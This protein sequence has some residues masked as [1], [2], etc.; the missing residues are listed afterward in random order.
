MKEPSQGDAAAGDVELRT[1]D[2]LAALKPGPRGRID[3]FGQTGVTVQGIRHT[4]MGKSAAMVALAAIEGSPSC[5]SVAGMLWPES[6]ES[7]AR[8][9]LRTLRH[10]LT[11]QLGVELLGSGENLSISSQAATVG[12]LDADQLVTEL[13][14]GGASRCMLLAD[15]GLLELEQFQEWLATARQRINRQQL[16][17]LDTALGAAMDSGQSARAIGFARACVM[18]EPLSERWHRQLMHTHTAC[19]DR[20]A[21]LAAYEACK[22]TLLDNLGATPDDRTRS[23]HLRI[24]RSQHRDHPTGEVAPAPAPVDSAA[25]IERDAQ[26]ER[27][28][29]A[30]SRGLSMVLH[31]EAGVG[32]T[33]LR[34]HFSQGKPVLAVKLRAGAGQ[35]PFSAL[36]Q[37]LLAAQQTHMLVLERI[38]R[39]ELSRVAPQAFPDDQPSAATI[40]MARLRE[41]VVHWSEMLRAKGVT[42]LCIDDLH[43]A[44]TRSQSAFAA[45]IEP[46]PDPSRALPVL[47]SYRSG[48]IAGDL[49]E[50]IGLQRQYHRL[51]EIRLER[52]SQ[53]GIEA[54][55]RSLGRDES[56]LPAHAGQLLAATGGNPLFVIE[57]TLFTHFEQVHGHLARVGT[58]LELLLQTRLAGCSDTAR[59]LAFTAGVAMA[60]FS[61]ELAACVMHRTAIDLM[62]AWSELQARGLFGENGLA[63]DLVRDAVLAALPNAIR[64]AMHRQV[65]G[66]LE[67]MGRLGAP[68]LRHWIAAQEYE[69]AL[70]HAVTQ[71]EIVAYAGAESPHDREA[72]FQIV[73][74]VDGQFL[75]D[76]LWV[77]TCLSPVD[78]SESLRARLETLIDRVEPI[79]SSDDAKAWVAYERAKLLI[80]WH[81]Q[82]E[83]AH[84]LLSA[85]ATKLKLS[86]RPAFWIE[87]MLAIAA[88]Q[89]GR[90]PN[91]HAR[92]A[93]EI[94]ARLPKDRANH[95]LSISAFIL[96]S[97]FLLE[98]GTCA[99]E[100][101]TLMRS[102]RAS[103]DRGTV[104]E[105][106]LR[107]AQVFCH[108]G[109]PRA[110]AR[111]YRYVAETFGANDP[112]EWVS[113]RCFIYGRAA[114]RC[115]R[116]DE[117]MVSME[118]LLGSESVL[119]LHARTGF[120]W[121]WTVL[122]RPDLAEEHIEI[123]GTGI[124]G[125]VDVFVMNSLLR[126]NQARRRG[127]LGAAELQAAID[128][129]RS[130]SASPAFIGM[131]ETALAT[132]VATPRE[133]VTVAAR[134]LELVRP[135][136]P[137]PGDVACAL[138]ALAEAH[139]DADPTSAAIRPLAL[140]G[141]ALARRGRIGGSDYQPDLLCRFARLLERSDPAIAASLTYVAARW[142]RNACDHLPERARES[143]VCDH[144]V[145][146]ILLRA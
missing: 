146:S 107:M 140:E 41:A 127:E 132:L 37:V 2:A 142:V 55:L 32:K 51:E 82:P 110:G 19:G 34:K 123:A 14:A 137:S 23:L 64:I 17:A 79:A 122:G 72:L 39:I 78:M 48:E 135:P 128:T 134:A 74:Q 133:R 143:F 1:G 84:A 92:R 81:C 25:L 93:A 18:L 76:H 116:Y 24:L 33:R 144:P 7:L 121:G 53:S 111:Q 145:N 73:E 57:L 108:G 138:L 47:L 113:A 20:A 30:F 40:S 136:H 13:A 56:T 80:Y 100:A 27:L 125:S 109:L 120:A 63:H 114:L 60:D 77:T 104:R 75:L 9:N 97:C 6:P 22:A 11:R 126:S 5:R 59:Q 52:L 15:V 87:W 118:P 8:N 117:A 95:F 68:V 99:R 86:E 54:L 28:E 21:A 130:A 67:E 26:L 16:E 103:G 139:A 131:L 38:H 35:D 70:P 36:A 105:V 96:R 50:A 43:Y 85:A 101:S 61:V 31:G 106:R 98:H 89:L 4:L 49:A 90:E 129:M 112:S 58:N 124:N 102:A 46:T 10:R 45:L 71:F 115:G 141:A 62:P 69:R 42:L 94:A 119:A 91:R 66:F 3:L 44:D 12:V 88:S 83:P 65:A 29:A